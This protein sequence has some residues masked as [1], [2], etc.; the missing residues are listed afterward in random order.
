MGFLSGLE[1]VVRQDEPLAPYVWFRL[2]GP[3]EFF[4]EPT[5]WDQL[6]ELVR[7]CRNEDV[8]VRVLGRGSNVLPR[9]E[10][11]RGVVV[12]LSAE[13]FR[14][15]QV[16]QSQ[17]S[18]GGGAPLQSVIT[19]AV[20]AGLAGLEQVVGI[21]GTIGGALHG[22]AGSHGGDVGQWTCSATVMTRKGE[23]IQ[24]GQD[25][26]QF[27]YRRSSL[28]DLAILE[29]SFQLEP[30]DSEEITR[31]MQKLWIVKKSQQPTNDQRT[32]CIF[33]DPRGMRA[34]ELIDEAGLEGTR[35]GGAE[36]SERNANYVIADDTATA[37]DVL[38]LV[39]LIRSRVNERTGVELEP[40]LDVW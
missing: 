31:R 2:G 4:A 11:V 9:D 21:P 3:A 14:E 32:G 13:A 10:G 12:R 26:L 34:E 6:G 8:P 16:R 37:A 36:V 39:D 22:N 30:E 29:A 5:S 15:I 19:E 18:A 27:A 28:D 20:R 38:R 33:R 40:Q 35:V 7:R 23:I 25:D 1:D 17:V 24:R